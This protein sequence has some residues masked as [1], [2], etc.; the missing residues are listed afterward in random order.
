MT[1]SFQDLPRDTI[2][3]IVSKLDI[4]TRNKLGLVFK[5]RIPVQIIDK[6]SRCLQVPSTLIG[7][8]D[9]WCIKLGPYVFPDRTTYT[10]QRYCAYG[11]IIYLTTHAIKGIGTTNYATQYDGVYDDSDD[12]DDGDISDDSDD[13]DDSDESDDSD[14]NVIEIVDYIVKIKKGKIPINHT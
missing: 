10:I 9:Y 11:S 14:D 4:D 1:S 3:K 13:S 8:D 6:I 2:L 12:N 7:V 5:L